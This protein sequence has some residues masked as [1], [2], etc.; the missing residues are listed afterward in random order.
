MTLNY[1]RIVEMYPKPNELVGHSIPDREIFAL[2]DRINW[3]AITSPHL[4]SKKQTKQS[5]TKRRL[6]DKAKPLKRLG[7]CGTQL[8]IY[9]TN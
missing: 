2:L 3:Q 7:F 1:Q 5:K 8:Q 4:C 6:P 9:S